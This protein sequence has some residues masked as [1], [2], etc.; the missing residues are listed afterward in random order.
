MLSL[1]EMKIRDSSQI[2]ELEQEIFTDAWTQT[3]IEETFAQAH[4]VIVVAEEE[5]EIQGYCLSLIHIS[6]P[7]RP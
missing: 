2:A 3:G 4:S 5:S 7:T 6:E 1:R